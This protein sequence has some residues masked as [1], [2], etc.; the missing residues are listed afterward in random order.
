MKVAL[1]T[2]IPAP[3]RTPLFNALAAKDGV[4]LEVLFLSDTD[5][6][7][8]HYRPAPDAARFRWSV[9]RGRQIHRGGH[10]IVVSRGV[11]RRLL[12]TRPDVIVVGGWNQPAYWLAA[13]AARILRIPLVLWVE[14][15]ARDARS[16][17]PL[18][19]RAK[20]AMIRRAAGFIVPGDASSVY[21]QSFGVDPAQI[22]TAG[23]AIDLASFRERLAAARR[24]RTEGDAPDAGAPQACTVLSVGRLDPEKGFDV[25]LAA[26]RMLLERQA[27]IAFVIVGD[28]SQSAQLRATAPANVSFV[29]AVDQT[30]VI[31]WYARADVFVLASLSEQWGMVLNEAAAAGLPIV[32]TEAAGG[33]WELIED[34]TN[35]FRIPSGDA[36]RL[37]DA[38]TKLVVD[39]TFREEAGRQSEQIGLR[40][41]PEVWADSV[42]EFLTSTAN[43]SQPNAA[44]GP[45][46][47]RR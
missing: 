19:E 46:R 3:F 1:L 37:A 21:L 7:R 29:G 24:E 10:W 17:S 30:S 40:H 26:A 12:R 22:A 2:E 41:T 39:K 6:R 44:I 32:A 23:N 25:L 27:P 28:G 9:L 38:L 43:R 36:E 14:S 42:T 47:L 16:E 18:L 45:S 13:A 35:G 20:R 34:G 15:T 5:P 31:E 4:E 8:L 33:A 11:V